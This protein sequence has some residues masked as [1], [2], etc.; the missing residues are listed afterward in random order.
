MSSGLHIFIVCLQTI[1]QKLYH[2]CF[3]SQPLLKFAFAFLPSLG[4]LNFYLSSS[5]LGYSHFSQAYPS[6]SLL[7]NQRISPLTPNLLPASTSSF[8][9]STKHPMTNFCCLYFFSF[10]FFS[11]CSKE[12]TIHISEATVHISEETVHISET[13]KTA[14]VDHR[15][16][17]IV[18]SVFFPVLLD[19]STVFKTIDHSLILEIHPLFFKDFFFQVNHFF[20]IFIE[21]CY[22]IA[23]VL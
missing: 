1:D 3:G 6:N 18:N 9:F 15:N 2:L 19:P 23:S 22:N 17:P 20:L 21:F 8:P 16:S 5:K 11:T 14:P 4:C 10:L 12:A 13:T 7:N